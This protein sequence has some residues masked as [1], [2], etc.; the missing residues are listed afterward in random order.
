MQSTA[1]RKF[2]RFELK[3]LISLEMAET[4]KK[5]IRR[6]AILDDYGGGNG[7]YKLTS[8]YYDSPN[9]TYYWEKIDG[10]R[11]RR[12][13]RIRWYETA[14]G[15]QDDSMVFVEIKQRVD[16]VTQKKR[17]PMKYK[18]ALLFCKEGIFP[19]EYEER[20]R[21][22]LEEM[23]E[24]IKLNNLEPKI[25]T[26]YDREAYIGGKYDMGF[27]LTFDRYVSYRYRDLR[28]DAGTSDGLM[29]PANM[30]IMEIKTNE[31]LP[32]WVS[33]MVANH[34]LNLIRVSK[35]CQ[36]IDKAKLLI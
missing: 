17:V 35:Y 36:G 3:Y 19:E 30:V 22:Y 1:I 26:S 8:L 29:I 32:S 5:D 2:N 16:R 4:L 14:A 13:L 10:L 23:Y 12:K 25:I 34:Q 7:H 33:E 21:P 27:R 18:E 15:L 24:M 20:D 6:Y 9:Y 28:L 31:R 11:F